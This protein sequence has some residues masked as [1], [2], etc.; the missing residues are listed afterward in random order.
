MSNSKTTEPYERLKN[1]DIGELNDLNSDVFSARYDENKDLDTV[2]H[3]L[4]VDHY[5]YD[6]TSGTGPYAAVVLDILSGPQVKNQATT[7]GRPVTTCLNLDEF[8]D[9]YIKELTSGAKHMPVVVKAKIPEFDVDIDWPKNND[10]KVRIDAHGEYWQFRSDDTLSNIS[11]GSIIWVSYKNNRDK[12]AID[13]KP[14]GKIIG[15][16][17]VASITD[18]VKKTS[19]KKSL[20]P[21]CQAARSVGRPFGGLYVSSTN[22]NPSN[23]GYG[24]PIRRIKGHIK[25][26]M[27]GNGTAATKE[28]FES[29]LRT[30]E[31]SP[32]FWYQNGKKGQS[33]PGPAPSSQNAFIWV[34]TLK[35]NGYMD[36]L[37]RP[38]SQGRE[39][40]IYAPM[41]L[42][43]TSPIEIKYYFHDKAGFGHAHINGPS[44]TVLQARNSLYPGNDFR[45]KI[46][47][48]I[49]DLNKAGRNYVLV[50]PEMAY[51]RGYGT[52]S[53]SRII[54]MSEGEAVVEGKTT[55]ETFRTR[56]PANARDAVKDYLNK[57]PI[58][59]NKNLLHVTP[60]RERE[61]AT[62]D[63]SFT[64]GKFGD[65][66]QE[67]LDVLD[68]HL[69]TM[70]DKI[71]YYSILAD[72]A[73]ATA[74]ASIVT[75]ISVSSN[76][77][78]GKESLLNTFSSKPA[79]RIDFVTDEITDS[80]AAYTNYFGGKSPS[81]V[82]K[83]ELYDYLVSSQAFVEFN[84]ITSPTQKTNFLFKKL[85]KEK[86]FD[87]H[88]KSGN[89]VRKFYFNS[90]GIAG[91]YISMHVGPENTKT[92]YAFAMLNEGQGDSMLQPSAGEGLFK[93]E[94][95]NDKPASSAVPDH[96]YALSGKP[97]IG[98]LEKLNKK[99]KELKEQN[100]SFETFL[101]QAAQEPFPDSGID[102]VCTFSKYSEYCNNGSLVTNAESLFF[103]SY[104]Q[105]LE[106]KRKYAEIVLL[107]EAEIRIQK[108]INNKD[109]LI[110]EK[111]AFEKL[112]NSSP[113]DLNRTNPNR[114]SWNNI[115]KSVNT[116]FKKSNF[117]GENSF[118][119][120]KSNEGYLYQVAG[121]IAAPEAY[122]KITNKLK[123]ALDTFVPDTLEKSKE[124]LDQPKAMSEMITLEGEPV[125]KPKSIVPDNNCS[126][127]D[128]SLP[129]NFEELSKFLG[130]YPK[131][132]DFNF[133]GRT[134]KTKTK[135][136][137]IPGFKTSTFKYPSRTANC[138]ITNKVSPPMWACITERIQKA[139]KEASEETRY[140]P[141]EI[142]AG[143][144]GAKDPKTSG[145][146][147]YKTGV[148]LHSYGL[149]FDLDP[150]ITGY[151]R[152]RGAL[153]SVYTGAWTPGFIEKHGKD[154]YELGV[155]KDKVEKL[156][157]NAYEGVNTPRMAENWQKAPSHYRGRGE[158]GD[159]KEKYVKIMNSAKGC[160]IIQ[161][162]TNPTLWLILF[163]EK[164]GM[165]WGNG[166]FLKKRHRG[167]SEWTIMQQTQISNIFGI[168]DIVSRIK[169]ISWKD[170][171]IDDH[172]H[173]HFWSGK[174]LIPWK[175]IDKARPEASAEQTVG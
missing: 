165:R 63:G 37:D 2:L 167:G 11:V 100:D 123:Q 16:H 1:L 83:Q 168:N 49:K 36:L 82:L 139:W 13:A 14:A 48:A 142:T 172:M 117:T 169:K 111:N 103:S 42:D 87:K 132:K 118:L 145:T 112:S 52:V 166:Q 24:P 94:G 46:G 55:G 69:G 109:Q 151:A 17:S 106:N 161:P 114:D 40:I 29:A 135:I 28:H 67:V 163:C 76:H 141:F 19:S 102:P 21:K 115:W 27:Y 107:I 90:G 4:F 22:P 47:P 39:T 59:T 85:G 93:S 164:S 113:Q 68:E 98:D 131:K 156:F 153:H 126:D 74:L 143:I 41:T 15:V 171:S 56:V 157:D 137:S 105:Y 3:E 7:G 33:I 60:L 127:L 12:I 155:Y 89:N 30:S 91:S 136:N 53:K 31:E 173:F 130:Y 174:S 140:Y 122:S 84:Y 150:F 162:G 66:H 44:T 99:Q 80:P 10:D 77:V 86:E 6:I 120:G 20:N 170:N 129:A 104:K 121:L 71:E 146:T 116:N 38:I 147:A 101:A 138:E 110:K 97:S 35:N 158:S 159:A 50:I 45:E 96:H 133:N 51:S 128:I 5:S 32:G 125:Y 78:L 148:S 64:G 75:D 18:I 175:D 25:T 61:F 62:F 23:F 8:E 54:K 57:L 58:E 92:N 152:G 149:A 81:Y 124:C 70:S 34:G 134:S 26:G 108:I 144:R 119:G 79:V 72:G 88:A 95:A 65:F 154:L 160:P 73:G 9:P 43:L